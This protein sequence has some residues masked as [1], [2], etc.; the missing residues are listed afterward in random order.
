[1]NKQTNICQYLSTKPEFIFHIS[2]K[3][4]DNNTYV[5]EG[6]GIYGDELELPF[7]SAP[8][9]SFNVNNENVETSHFIFFFLFGFK[10]R[11]IN[12]IEKNRSTYRL[13]FENVNVSDFNEYRQQSKERNARLQAD[14]TT[15]TE[16]QGRQ[17]VSLSSP[18]LSNSSRIP[19]VQLQKIAD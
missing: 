2:S 3:S 17:S 9:V 12:E 8:S 10:P 19:S 11:A 16:N 14:E 7:F 1:M 15:T 6:W 13:T 5:S 18:L 4:M